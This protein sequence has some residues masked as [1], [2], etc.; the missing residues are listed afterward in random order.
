MD[1]NASSDE[2]EVILLQKIYNIRSVVFMR[3]LISIRNIDNNNNDT[4]ISR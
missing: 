4:A 3:G 1:L 2:M